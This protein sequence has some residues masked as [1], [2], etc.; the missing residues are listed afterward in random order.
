M[1]FQ[2]DHTFYQFGA[3]FQIHISIV[4]PYPVLHKNITVT[5]DSKLN[6]PKGHGEHESTPA[7]F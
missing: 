5:Y 3:K 2:F 6:A 4:R 1:L 7:T